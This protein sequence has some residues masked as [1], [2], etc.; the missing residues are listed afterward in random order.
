MIT[1]KFIV[2]G[3]S[4]HTSFGSTHP[5]PCVSTPSLPCG[6]SQSPVPIPPLSVCASPSRCQV[7]AVTPRSWCGGVRSHPDVG[8]LLADTPDLL[9]VLHTAADRKR[10][11]I[12]LN[13]ACFDTSDYNCNIILGAIQALCN[14]CFLKI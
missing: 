13:V 2:H 14:D 5:S 1:V 8:S 11:V 4:R 10:K 9:F 6:A 12:V 7:P 3:T